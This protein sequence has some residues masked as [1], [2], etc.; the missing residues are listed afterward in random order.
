V[1]ADGDDYVTISATL[2][3]GDDLDFAVVVVQEGGGPAACGYLD[4]GDIP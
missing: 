2:D 3:N 1:G 4:P